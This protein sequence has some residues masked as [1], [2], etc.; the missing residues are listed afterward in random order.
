MQT[1][2]SF[3][4]TSP[5]EL[6]AFLRQVSVFSDL[7]EEALAEVEALL[8]PVVVTAGT[9]LFTRGDPG[10]CM[11][12][13]VEGALRVHD[14]DL[15]FNHLGPREV[16]G[17]ISL[18]DLEVRTATVTAE[19]DT[20]LYRLDRHELHAL[21]ACQPEIA[22]GIIQ[23]L[24]SYLREMA[25]EMADDF[26]YMQQFNRVI[27]AAQAVEAGTYA[28]DMLNEVAQRSDALGQLARVF[29]QM[30]HEVVARETQL[31]QQ[32]EALQIQIQ[33]DKSQY[34]HQVE[35]ITETDYF[36]NLQEFA[37]NLR[38]QRSISPAVQKC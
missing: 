35:A 32:V 38:Q 3:P 18:L 24:S 27:T 11:Y 23:V 14:G 8:D 10:D 31:R 13:I 9:V 6:V 22:N 26:A 4:I 21:M 15:V 28:E 30:A 1:T 36:Q 29:Q 16:V 5:A 20:L 33:I 19:V 7:S 25:R 37:R 2:T 12:I 17:E 34:Q